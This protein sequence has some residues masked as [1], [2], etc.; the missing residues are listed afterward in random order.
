MRKNRKVGVVGIIITII[1]LIILV[2]LTNLSANKFSNSE[3]VFNKLVMPIQNGLTNLKNKIAG[4]NSFFEDINKLKEENEKLNKENKE[5]E[6]KLRELE[7]IKAENSTLRE[8][9]NMTEKYSKYSSKPAYIINR[10]ISNLSD[11]F[12]INAGKKDGIDVNMPVIAENGLV[13][14][15][16]SVTDDTS[17]VQPIID[18]S[19][20]ISCTISTSRDSVIA[21]GILGSTNTLKLT[22]IPTEAEIVLDDTIETSGIWGI[23]PKGIIIGK[24]KEI[25]NTKNITDR[26]AIIETSVDFSKLETV[27]VITNWCRRCDYNTPNT[28]VL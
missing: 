24:V 27:L 22:Y 25:I 15:V 20:S 4:N 17:K 19:S 2:V 11:T 10:D 6:Q 16:I 8:Y 21:T 28:G 26:Y 13:G 7:I 14:Y 12:V 9:V 23:Y 1:I 18:P 3:N 5:L